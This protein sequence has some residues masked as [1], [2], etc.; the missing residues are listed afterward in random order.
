MQ[1]ESGT[2]MS[3][4]NVFGPPAPPAPGEPPRANS[5]VV[6]AVSPPGAGSAGGG[7]PV[8]EWSGAFDPVSMRGGAPLLLWPAGAAAG[9]GAAAA[10]LLWCARA[11]RAPS[12]PLPS[13]PRRGRKGQ[14]HWLVVWLDL[15]GW[16]L[17][18]WTP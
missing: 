2:H 18:G 7:R 3:T 6:R 15:R 16:T 5:L 8:T 1:L 10:V 13:R 12:V 14:V 4:L 9:E 17:R 11:P